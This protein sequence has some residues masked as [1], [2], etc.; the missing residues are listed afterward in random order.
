IDSHSPDGLTVSVKTGT[1][2]Y[3]RLRLP[4]CGRHQ[5]TNLRLAVL[6]L[7]QVKRRG[8]SKITD[9]SIRAGL[10]TIPARSGLHGRLEVLNRSPLLIADVGHNPGGITAAL[11]SLRELVRMPWIALFGV[12]RDK[13]YPRMIR[14]IGD[15]ARLTVAVT[16]ATGR[17]LPGK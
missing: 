1:K 10:A 12:M 4:L 3:D 13:D 17:A 9:R 6:A 7:E 15:A 5:V 11:G 2:Y 8:Y 16:P 14:A